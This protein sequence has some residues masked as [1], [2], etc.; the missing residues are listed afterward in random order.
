MRGKQVALP[1]PRKATLVAF[2]PFRLLRFLVGL[3]SL[4]AT[5]RTSEGRC[6]DGEGF[7]SR[8]WNAATGLNEFFTLRTTVFVERRTSPSSAVACTRPS[9][10]ALLTPLAVMPRY[11]HESI[12]PRKAT[13]KPGKRAKRAGGAGSSFGLARASYLRVHFK[14]R[15]CESATPHARRTRT[16]P[17]PFSRVFR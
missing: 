17:P 12:L 6:D 11:A 10:R 7:S 15:G 4:L 9:I 16:K 5:L 1:R 8:A 14:V 3:C 2:A 13:S